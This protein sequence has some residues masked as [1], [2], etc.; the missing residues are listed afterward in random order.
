MNRA[1]RVAY[2]PGHAKHH[3][4]YFEE[5]TGTAWVGDDAGIRIP[6]GGVIPVTP[7]PDVDIEAWNATIDR[8]LA[9]NPARIVPTHFG[10]V[11]DPVAHFEALREGLARWAGRV[12]ASLAGEDAANPDVAGDAARADAFSAWVEEDLRGAHARRGGRHLHQRLRRRRLV[13]GPRPLLAHTR[14]SHVRRRF[15][16]RRGAPP[17]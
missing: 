4:A 16:W 3:V 14:I 2:T 10:P 11:D 17:R 8:V 12:R 9:W 1:L 15:S 5:D 7:P 6:P 13:V